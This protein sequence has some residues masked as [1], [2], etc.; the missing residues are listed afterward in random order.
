MINTVDLDTRF[1]NHVRRAALINDEAWQQEIAPPCPRFGSLLTAALVGLVGRIG[2]TR[3][4]LNIER[5]VVV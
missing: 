2:R 3:T 4:H 5:P 1:A